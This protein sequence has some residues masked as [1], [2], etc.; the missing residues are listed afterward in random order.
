MR[1]VATLFLLIIIS[2]FISLVISGCQNEYEKRGY[3]P[4]PQNRPSD[5]ENSKYRQMGN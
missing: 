1:F 4:L 3:S 2:G 5:W